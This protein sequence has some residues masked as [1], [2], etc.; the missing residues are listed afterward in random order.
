MFKSIGLSIV[1]ATMAL[2]TT[3]PL[4][5]NAATP[6][7]QSEI[8]SAP[9]RTVYSALAEMPSMRYFDNATGTA[10][11]QVDIDKTGNMLAASVLKSSGDTLLDRSALAAAHASTFAPEMRDCSPVAGSYVFIVDFDQD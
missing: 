11:I 1:L 4:A 5:A 6:S 9:A 2:A 10:N 3:A 8:C 7:A